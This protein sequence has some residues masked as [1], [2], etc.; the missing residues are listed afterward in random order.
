MRG[1]MGAPTGTPSRL[2][3]PPQKYREPAVVEARRGPSS[4]SRASTFAQCLRHADLRA[5]QPCSDR[6][7]IAASSYNAGSGTA[8][9]TAHVTATSGTPMRS[10]CAKSAPARVDGAGASR[11]GGYAGRPRT[12]AAARVG[13]TE[14][15]EPRGPRD[16]ERRA[17][18]EARELARRRAREH[19][20]H[21]RA[22]LGLGV[23]ASEQHLGVFKVGEAAPPRRRGRFG[24]VLALA[25]PPT[26][27]I[28]TSGRRAARTARRPNATR[29]GR[30]DMVASFD[31][32]GTLGTGA[33][34]AAS[35][36]ARAR[37]PAR[38]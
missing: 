5:A 31:A 24:R 38:T 8:A 15:D 23:R 7:P 10:H 35:S 28:A 29:F 36:C 17:G 25:M 21:E 19:E 16:E 2:F 12:A 37:A 1:Q 34:E 14:H 9:P 20:Q 26:L 30:D 13:R 27:V 18:R 11:R 22:V 3:A 4:D 6:W 32:D 33:T